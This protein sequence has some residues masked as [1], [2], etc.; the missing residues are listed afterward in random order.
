MSETAEYLIDYFRSRHGWRCRPGSAAFKDLTAFAH[1]Q[2]AAP[3]SVEDLYVLFCISH[4][5]KPKP[6]TSDIVRETGNLKVGQKLLNHSSISVTAKYAHVLDTEVADAM[7]RVAKSRA[8]RKDGSKT[9][10]Q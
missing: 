2:T 6:L 9:G 8:N 10:G 1:E 4:G 3:H 7:E 5:I